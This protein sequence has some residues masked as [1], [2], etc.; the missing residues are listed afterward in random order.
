MLIILNDKNDIYIMVDN[1][2][3]L[4]PNDLLQLDHF[5]LLSDLIHV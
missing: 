3:I 2:L 1:N 4:Y 5:N